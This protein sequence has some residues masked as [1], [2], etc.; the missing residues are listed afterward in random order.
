MNLFKR[1]TKYIDMDRVK[2]L[3][4]EKI[5]REQIAELVQQQEEILAELE[6][7]ETEKSKYNWRRELEEAMP[8][9]GDPKIDAKVTKALKKRS[10]P[11]SSWT[12]PS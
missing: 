6:Y 10:S 2:E 5:K 12:S 1:A 4:E 11:L 3:R 9:T 8:K 7:I